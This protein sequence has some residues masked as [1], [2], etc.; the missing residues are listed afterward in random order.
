MS[1]ELL[2]PERF[3]IPEPEDSRQT[4]QSDCYAFGMVIYEV[5]IREWTFWCERLT[6]G[7]IGS[8]RTPPIPRDRLGYSNHQCDHGGN[9]TGGTGGGEMPGIQG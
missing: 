4:R 3:G 2:D 8:V 9:S 6:C 1:P 7:T 5:G